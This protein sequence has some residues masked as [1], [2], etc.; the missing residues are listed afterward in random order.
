MV[1]AANK[2]SEGMTRRSFSFQA[3]IKEAFIL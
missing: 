3:H 1:A 2:I